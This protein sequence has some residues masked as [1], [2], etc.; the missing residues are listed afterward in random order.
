[1]S[2]SASQIKQYWEGKAEKLGTDPSATM[3]DVILRSLEI[4]A[5]S[6]R[7]LPGDTMLDVG[8]G[9]LSGRWFSPRMPNP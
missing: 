8:A 4:E 2:P 1:M 5:I 9:M 6:K 3:K 7:L